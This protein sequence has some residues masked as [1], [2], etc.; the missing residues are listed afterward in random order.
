VTDA[1]RKL[2]ETVRQGLLVRAR[3]AEVKAA[4]LEAS[5]RALADRLESVGCGCLMEQPLLCDPCRQEA[6]GI[7]RIALGERP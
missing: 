2:S 4:R 1:E 5:L 7:I 3:E 6:R